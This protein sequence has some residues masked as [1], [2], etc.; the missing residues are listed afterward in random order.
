MTLV[1]L[2]LALS[3][4]TAVGL[5]V[6]P[7][8]LATDC[9]AQAALLQTNIGLVPKLLTAERAAIDAQVA[10]SKGYCTGS[11]PAD[12]TAASTAVEA[13]NTQIAA[14]LAIAKLRP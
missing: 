2:A 7:T 10:Q 3:G 1:I 6:T 4:C 13:A 9:D 11:L 12:Q 14:T 8:T 5:P